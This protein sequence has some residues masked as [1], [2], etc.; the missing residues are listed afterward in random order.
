MATKWKKWKNNLACAAFVLGV[1]L[2]ISGG[3]GAL[4]E[5]RYGGRISFFQE[6]LGSS[7]YQN[8]R[9]FRDFIADRLETFLDMGCG[10]PVYNSDYGYYVD[11]GTAEPA[12]AIAEDVIEQEYTVE[13]EAGTVFSE[14]VMEDTEAEW[15]EDRKKKVIEG[16]HNTMKKDP[17][18]LYRIS[19][20][21]KELYTN[22]AAGTW[23]GNASKLPE[24][25]NFYLYFDG[26]KADVKKD[27]RSLDIYGDGIYREGEGF[28]IPGYRNFT[29]KNKWKNVQVTIL[30]AKEPTQFLQSLKDRYYSYSGSGLYGVY[31]DYFEE[32]SYLFRTIACLAGG[33]AGLV[34]Y[35]FL[36]SGKRELNK[37][38]A[39]LT[40]KIWFEWKVLLGLILP[41]LLIIGILKEEGFFLHAYDMAIVSNVPYYEYASELSY[42]LADIIPRYMEPLLLGFWLFY[43]FLVDLCRNKKGYQKGIYGKCAALLQSRDL[44]LPL[45]QR[46][47]KRTYVLCAIAAVLPV[48]LLLVFLACILMDY[49]MLEAGAVVWWLEGA[50]ALAA[51]LLAVVYFYQKKN[52]KFAEELSLLAEQIGGIRDGKYEAGEASVFED[53]DLRH[54]AEELEDIRQGLE[55]AVEERTSSERMKVELVANVSHDIKTPLTSIISYIQLLK[56]EEGL[57]D[58]ISD[59]IRILDEKSERLKNMVQDVFAISKAASGQLSVE[60]KELDLCKLLYQTLADMEEPITKSPVM[61]KTEIPKEPVMVCTDGQ[62]M[63]RVFQ[64]L[65]VNA[66][67]YSLKGSRVYVTLKAEGA[68]AVASVKNTSSEEL[69]REIDFAERF[70]RGD[71]SRTDGGSGLGLSIARSFTE[72]CGGTFE[73]EMIA[74]LFVVTVS[75][76]RADGGGLSVA[77]E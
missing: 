42:S 65:I 76:P 28:C 39:A 24:G 37:R 64:N 45:S 30:A 5:W 59:Y 27:G 13:A 20:R 12:E 15:T 3:A 1:S 9:Q 75:L 6:Y 21:G 73:L 63:Y 14:E 71:A 62:R 47:V 2:L 55:T 8:S 57:P 58:D 32:Q 31:R 61:V 68:L 60:L 74:D 77:I 43:A 72:A 23:D 41:I 7:D 26:E 56:Q 46:L 51:A 38:L 25:Y 10:D 34:L 18:V 52:R 66:I 22:I 29:A 69:N 35:L 16:I 67:K 44:K 17:N 19:C 54:M 33:L 49:Q 53:A 36:R 70:T 40:E 4:R 48:Y 11:Y 50:F